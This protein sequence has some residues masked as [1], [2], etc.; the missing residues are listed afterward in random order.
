MFSS[1]LISFLLSF[2]V[3]GFYNLAPLATN[4]F[5]NLDCVSGKSLKGHLMGFLFSCVH[6]LSF[7][8]FHPFDLIPIDSTIIKPIRGRW[9]CFIVL[10]LLYIS[11]SCQ[12]NLHFFI[13]KILFLN[14]AIYNKQMFDVFVVFCS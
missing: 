6:L 2:G 11:S 13:H 8:P 14:C 4:L 1:F 7:S 3:Y 10:I 9:D 5:K 12:L